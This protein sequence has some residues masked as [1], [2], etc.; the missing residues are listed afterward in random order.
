M[1]DEPIV[2]IDSSSYRPIDHLMTD[3]VKNRLLEFLRFLFERSSRY[4]YS[5]DELASKIYI[6]D[7]FPVKEDY[8]KKPSIVVRRQNLVL[9]NRG[10]GH[11]LGWTFS[12]NFGSSYL[13]LLQSQ[14]VIE[15]Y[16]REGLEAENIA[17]L[18]FAGLLFYRRQ[19]NKIG[20]I[21]DV[22]TA[23]I[24]EE[25]PQMTSSTI[26]LAMVPVQLSFTFAEQWSTEEVGEAIFKGITLETAIGPN[27][28]G[29]DPKTH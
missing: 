29:N 13:D 20:R 15:C 9:T 26:T 28:A 3:E 1:S 10:V 4:T 16:S 19:L 5:D 2:F 8:E 27:F 6:S 7:V 17:N 18:V 12:E 24:G 21:H 14:V 23:G 25:T 11:F 22:L